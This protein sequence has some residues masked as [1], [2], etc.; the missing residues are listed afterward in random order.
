MLECYAAVWL[1]VLSAIILLD[2]MI[3][4][5]FCHMFFVWLFRTLMHLYIELEDSPELGERNEAYVIMR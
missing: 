2:S 1:Y 3:T 5:C 4:V